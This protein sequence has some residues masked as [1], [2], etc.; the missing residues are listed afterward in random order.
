LPLV[1]EEFQNLLRSLAT[2]SLNLR[3]LG[4]KGG[5]GLLLAV[6]ERLLANVLLRSEQGAEAL[7]ARGGSWISD[8]GYCTVA[9]R[10]YSYYPDYRDDSIGFRLARSSGN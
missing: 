8:A 1:Q 6:A 3:Q 2:R 10:D 7:L 4:F 9:Y 5:F